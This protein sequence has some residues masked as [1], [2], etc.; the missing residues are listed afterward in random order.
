MSRSSTFALMLAAALAAPLATAQNTTLYSCP[1][2]GGGD[3]VTR[4]F[5]VTG[6]PGS[7]LST[8]TVTYYAGSGDGTYDVT[9][10]AHANSYGGAQVGPTLN[11][12]LNLVGTGPV[13]VTYDFGGA[14]VAPGSTVTFSQVL[15]SGPGAPPVLFYDT[16]TGTCTNV[17]ET[18]GTTPPLDT[19]RRNGMGVT[20]AGAG[21]LVPVAG[22]SPVPALSDYTLVVQAALLAAAGVIVMR[23]RR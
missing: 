14:A 18:N 2:G 10:T 12:V 22:I 13:A 21:S 20:I 6:Y 9:M 19:F 5:Y 3:Q 8:V 16:G 23:R 17:I 4:G 1:T 11:K 7:T 15:N